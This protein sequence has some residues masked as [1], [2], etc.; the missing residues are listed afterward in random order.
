MTAKRPIFSAVF[1]FFAKSS[2]EAAGVFFAFILVKMA[3]SA[4]FVYRNGRDAANFF[5]APFLNYSLFFFVKIGREAAGV[6]FK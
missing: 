1:D 3:R 5:K 4:D 2:R 6:F